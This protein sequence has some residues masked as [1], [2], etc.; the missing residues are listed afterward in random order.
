MQPS[1]VAVTLPG[2]TWL[3]GAPVDLV[4]LRPLSGHDELFVSEHAERMS[5]AALASE[6]LGRC[7]IAVGA[8]PEQV[9]GV[10][11]EIV[12][13]LTVGD[14]EALLLHLR[15]MSFGE[16]L[17][18]VAD[19]DGCHEPMDVELDARR[20]LGVEPPARAAMHEADGVAFRLPTGEDLEVVAAMALDDPDGAA[21]ALLDRCVGR[22]LSEDATAAVVAAMAALDPL[23]EISVQLACPACGHVT[24]AVLD[25][26]EL[27][28][29]ELWGRR[30][31]L[32]VAVHLL[33]VHYHWREG[34]ILD[35]L[36]TRRRRYVQV[37]ADALSLA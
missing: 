7:V 4:R 20:V 37:L 6:L 16:R 36:A 17:E 8:G 28:R 3:D 10:G 1:A 15:S 25:T 9:A 19:C 11:T 30:G 13:R 31:E 32:D 34:E 35:L 5:A 18:F 26:G 23:A 21:R 33:A 14:R 12:R 2:T 29:R 24:A 22:E 27:L